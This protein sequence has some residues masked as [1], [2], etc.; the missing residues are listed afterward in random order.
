MRKNMLGN[1]MANGKSSTSPTARTQQTSF[2]LPKCSCR[3][4]YAPL[5]SYRQFCDKHCE[6]SFE[7]NDLSFG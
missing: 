3:H 1:D 4:C 5:S 2:F 7:E 6:R